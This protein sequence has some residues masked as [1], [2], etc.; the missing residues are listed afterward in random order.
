[1]HIVCNSGSIGS[2]DKDSCKPNKSL[3]KRKNKSIE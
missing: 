2:H 1:M 3:I